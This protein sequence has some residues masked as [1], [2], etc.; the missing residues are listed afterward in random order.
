MVTRNEEHYQD[1]LQR[2]TSDW[3]VRRQTP[4]VNAGYA[5]RV[6]AVSHAIDGFVQY[7]QHVHPETEIQ[8]VFFGCG[9]DVIGLWSHSLVERSD[10]IRILELDMPSVCATKK[11]LLISKGLV[12]EMPGPYETKEEGLIG[13]I[14][15]AP[16]KNERLS[17][18]DYF[19]LPVDL[20]DT[21]A[22]NRIL[23]ESLVMDPS[24][25]PTLVVSELVVAYLR[26]ENTDQ[27][28]SWCASRLI[29]T[30]GSA[31]LLLEP[32]G[33][34]ET[35]SK[36]VTSVLE[37]YRRKYC[38]M[39]HSKMERGKSTNTPNS[40]NDILNES[41]VSSS[42]YPIGVSIRSVEKRFR[43]VGFQSAHV[44]TLGSAAAHSSK[45]SE[46]RIPEIF[47]EHAALILHL[48][49]YV[50]ATAFPHGSD[51]LLSR[52]MCPATYAGSEIPPLLAEED[53]VVYTVLQPRD[54]IAMRDLFFKTYANLFD[55]YPAVR[56]MVNGILNREFALS[57]D[58]G[59]EKADDDSSEITTRYKSQGGCFFVAVRYVEGNDGEREVIGCVG[60]RRCERKDDLNTLEVFRLAVHESCRGKGIG[61][62]LLQ[63]V[64]SFGRSRKSPKLVAH[65]I[66][67]LERALLV[68]EAC[69]YKIEKDSP[70]GALTM[71]T[72]FKTLLSGTPTKS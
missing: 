48:Q 54:E 39:F 49:S 37:G 60:V 15:T 50:V 11:D 40:K 70:L 35:K 58:G 17:Q 13:Q 36:Q 63:M 21:S 72:Y 10:R 28:F 46:F 51:G 69:G 57:S 67:C 18:P 22:L 2:A 7:H 64:E 33:H 61:R 43:T 34:D 44:T 53:R 14:R 29:R 66:T 30:S 20:M 19:L 42:F 32:L 65:T 71:R 41:S 12:T 62:H 45:G 5:T 4:L 59:V 31:M 23:D 8:I 3:K 68:Y 6:L 56:K 47:D 9:V 52:L 38:Q 25:A 27:L 55:S 26:P 1:L 24:N 16:P